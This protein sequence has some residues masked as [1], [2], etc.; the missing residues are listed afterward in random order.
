VWHAVLLQ[1]LPAAA[2]VTIGAVKDIQRRVITRCMV[3]VAAAV[4]QEMV[5]AH[6]HRVAFIIRANL[7]QRR[8]CRA[9]T[10]RLFMPCQSPSLTL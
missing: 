9:S 1:Q 5:K 8:Y 3:G 2:A 7:G 10:V 6:A 4:A